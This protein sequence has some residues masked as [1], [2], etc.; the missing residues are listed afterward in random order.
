MMHTCKTTLVPG[1]SWPANTSVLYTPP[2]MPPSQTSASSS[3]ITATL[4]PGVGYAFN[5]IKHMTGIAS[6][7]LS[8]GLKNLASDGVI[9]MTRIKSKTPLGYSYIYQLKGQK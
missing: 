5:T 8:R 3:I 6:S 2:P 1:V 9:T 4:N 7:S